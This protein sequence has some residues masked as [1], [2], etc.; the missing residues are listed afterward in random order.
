MIFALKGDSGGPLLCPFDRHKKRWFVGGIVSW[1]IKC[2]H[3]QLPGVYAYVPKY[4]S[5][6]REQMAKYS[7]WEDANARK[8]KKSKNRRKPNFRIFPL[9]ENL[10]DEFRNPGLNEFDLRLSL[11][12][13]KTLKNFSLTLNV[14]N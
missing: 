4:V 7:D 12:N 8:K 11:P 1:G 3:P 9:Q 14:S 10:K 5:W 6:I 2:A 13:E